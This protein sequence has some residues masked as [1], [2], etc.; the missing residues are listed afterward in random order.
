MAS[1]D[2]N[3]S[4]YPINIFKIYVTDISVWDP[5]H[6]TFWWRH[7]TSL[8]LHVYLFHHLF[9]FIFVSF[10]TALKINKCF[11][12]SCPNLS[13]RSRW[14]QK[15]LLCQLDHIH[16]LNNSNDSRANYGKELWSY[17]R[18]L[19]LEEFEPDSSKRWPVCPD[20]A[21]FESSWRKIHLQK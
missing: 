1:I 18:C 16:W 5:N 13:W 2:R 3:W 11:T 21:I 20:C 4:N 19:H 12:I 15:Q 17:L 10:T 6:K 8:F 7:C 14:G 9:F